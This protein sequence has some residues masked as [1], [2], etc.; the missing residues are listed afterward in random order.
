MSA[1][2]LHDRTPIRIAE[3]G[4]ASEVAALVRSLSGYYL[5]PGVTELPPW[6]TA[7]I[8]P[9]AFAER[10][11]SNDFDGF[12]YVIEQRI[13]GY[14]SIKQ[15]AHLY[16]LFVD[17]AHQRKG[18]ATALWR[19]ARSRLNIVR[20]TVRSSLFA[21]PVYERLGFSVSGEVQ[22]KDGVHYQI[23]ILNDRD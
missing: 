15:R 2:L 10:F 16:H 22:A 3:V 20:C 7:S 6:L 23:M 21:V 11:S 13:V 12:V 17:E 19:F 4:D 9:E 14:L 1:P 5:S 8:T 18:I